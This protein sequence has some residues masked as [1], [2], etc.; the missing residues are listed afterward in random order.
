M[1]RSPM[2][3]ANITTGVDLMTTPKQI[4]TPSEKPIRL[5]DEFSGS[6]GDLGT[7]LP[8]VL[9]VITVAGLN[10]T[11]VFVG[12]GLFYVLSGWFYTI[13]MA[14]QPMKAAAAAVLVHQLTIPEIAAAGF[15]MGAVLLILGL[16]GVINQLAR[17]TPPGVTGGIQVGL[18]LSLALMGLKMVHT[19]PLLGWVILAGMLVLLTSRRF[20]ASIF[21]LV[22]G[23][24]LAFVLHPELSL[25]SLSWG[26]QMPELILP[27]TADFQRGF[28]MLV[29]PQLPLTLTNAVLVT[30]ALSAELYGPRAARV[31]EKNLSLS[32]GLANLL[33]APWGG[34][35]MCHGSGGV[36]AHYRFGGRTRLTP[37]IIGFAL[38]L[39]GLCLGNDGVKL[40]Q[41]IPEAV[42]GAL[43]FYS[44]VDL[45]SAARGIDQRNDVF[46]VLV[47][48]ALTLAINP[49]IAFVVGLIVAKGLKL[50]IVKI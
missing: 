25:P 3:L 31:T 42:L 4:Q 15:I 26:L 37:F 12:F 33:V 19:D 40:L 46:L 44:G 22:V 7:F 24:G 32:M 50:N 10:S 41:L 38:V 6:I 30:A 49:A 48:A 43:L 29:L 11:S 39:L 5:L 14:V 1:T 8:Y 47:V 13:P 36:A 17:L 18:G 35:M 9:A 34:F 23:T 45:A 28:L 16:T 21:A 2:V 20:P 27:K